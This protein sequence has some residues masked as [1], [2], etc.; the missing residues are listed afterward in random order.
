MLQATLTEVM[1]SARD[2]EEIVEPTRYALGYHT[3]IYCG[4]PPKKFT[5]AIAANKGA[6]EV[7]PESQIK[8]IGRK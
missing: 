5:V 4:S 3:C 8:L 1:C 2:C 6:Y 7:I